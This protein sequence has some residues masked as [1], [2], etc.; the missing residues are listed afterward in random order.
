MVIT[1]D[2]ALSFASAVFSV[3]PDWMERPLGLKHRGISHNVPVWIVIF[4]LFIPILFLTGSN[5]LR[6]LLIAF[7]FGILSH[8]MADALT[9]SGVQYLL[10]GNHRLSFNICKTGSLKEYIISM[11]V[12]IIAVTVNIGKLSDRGYYVS[13]LSKY[14]ELIV[15]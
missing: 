1:G 8:L 5:I 15:K 11:S 9:P 14:A 6:T 3:V 4:S 13:L 10:T 2:V 7:I 12:L